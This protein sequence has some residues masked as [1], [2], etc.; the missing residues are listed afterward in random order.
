MLHNKIADINLQREALANSAESNDDFALMAKLLHDAFS[1]RKNAIAHSHP[2]SYA[3]ARMWP[4][5][6][7]ARQTFLNLVEFFATHHVR[8]IIAQKPAHAGDKD[9][10]RPGLSREARKQIPWEER[11]LRDN[12]PVGPPHAFAVKRQKVLY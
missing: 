12:R 9:G 1:S 5:K 4:E 8:L 10:A 3:D 11:T 2:R 6:Q 7:P